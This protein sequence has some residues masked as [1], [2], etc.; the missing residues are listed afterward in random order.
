LP[1]DHVCC[2]LFVTT[3]GFGVPVPTMAATVYQG[4]TDDIGGRTSDPAR[5]GKSNK[6]IDLARRHTKR[7]CAVP[8]EPSAVHA[9]PAILLD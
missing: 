7:G 2:G 3:E 5:S 4:L 8:N 6:S 9:R 1:A